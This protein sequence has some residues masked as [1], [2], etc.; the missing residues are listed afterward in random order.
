MSKTKSVWVCQT[1]GHQAHKWAG[2]CSACE[3]W[4]SFVE[5]LVTPKITADLK[6][7]AG[8]LG[9]NQVQ[10]QHLNQVSTL[11]LPRIVTPDGEFNRVL[12]G[13]IVPGSLVL[14]GGEPGIGKSTLLL[15]LALQ[16]NNQQVIYVSGEESASQIKLRA[17]RLTGTPEQVMV[18]T[19]TDTTQIIPVLQQAKPNWVVIDSI[20]TIY[21]PLIDSIAGSVS[22]IRQCTAELMR[23]AKE[24]QIP[25]VLIGHINKEGNLAGPKVL[26]HLVDT[27]LQF[28]GDRHNSYRIVRTLKNRFGPSSELGIYEMRGTGLRQVTNPAELLL[29]NQVSDISGMSVGAILEGNRPLLVEVQALV[30]Q[31]TYGTPQRTATGI[32]SR[33]LAM[34]IAVI[35]KRGGYRLGQHDVFLN[36]AGG[37]KVEDPALDL[38]ISVAIVASLVDHV[39]D[40]QCCFAAEVGLGG[41]LRA[42]QK[43]DLRLAETEKLG[44]KCLVTA[45]YALKHLEKIP[46]GIQVLG[47][48]KITDCFQWL[49]T[50]KIIN[51]Q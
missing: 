43:L 27:V 49:L 23:F 21:S 12:G 34:L 46:K 14:I 32:D 47:F 31:A 38:A 22:Q 50:S 18:L 36:I 3:S 19:E 30:S 37:L 48:E 4:N 9:S 26:E 13:G 17:D 39:L 1:C 2:K 44:F 24:S 20:Q 29:G 28:E 42:I 10:I 45:K 40:N 35:E 25:V 8:K 7:I 41:E 11:D 15:Q 16:L 33:R 5:E 6:Q 51:N